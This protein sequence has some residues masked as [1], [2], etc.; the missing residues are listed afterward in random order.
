MLCRV[1]PGIVGAG[2]P[3]LPRMTS[4]VPLASFR[5]AWTSCAAEPSGAVSEAPEPAATNNSVG[6]VAKLAS[7][8][9]RET[10][11]RLDA[12]VTVSLLSEMGRDFKTGETPLLRAIRGIVCNSKFLFEVR[13]DPGWDSFLRCSML[14]VS[15][16]NGSGELLD[17][18]TE[19]EDTA[20]EDTAR[21][22][23]RPIKL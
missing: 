21:M 11:E 15:P 9:R 3:P 14:L 20:F 18:I 23:R 6:I 19:A 12:S 2:P 1:R 10:G 17:R 5:A 22:P 13:L 8:L 4:L 7:R 16:R